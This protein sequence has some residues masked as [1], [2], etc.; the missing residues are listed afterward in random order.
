MPVRK[1]YLQ[2]PEVR[3]GQRR[4]RHL[5]EVCGG[6]GSD[7][8]PMILMLLYYV[9]AIAAGIA[10]VRLVV[11]RRQQRENADLKRH[12]QRRES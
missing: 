4:A 1:A 12:L 5:Y 7:E 6:K 11:N 2:L 9:A 8:D 3:R 10:V